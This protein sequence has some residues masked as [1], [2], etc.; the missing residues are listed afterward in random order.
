MSYLLFIDKYFS[1]MYILVRIMALRLF[2]MHVHGSARALKCW[3]LAEIEYLRDD[4]FL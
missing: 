1:E 4:V 2:D 3:S